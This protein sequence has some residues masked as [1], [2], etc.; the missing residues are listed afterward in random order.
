MFYICGLDPKFMDSFLGAI[1]AGVV[2]ADG[3]LSMVSD[4]TPT[5]NDRPLNVN[6]PAGRAPSL[7]SLYEQLSGSSSLCP[8]GS[9]QGGVGG[10][11]AMGAAVSG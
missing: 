8:R 10:V 11:G 2:S 6:P 3:D 1:S 9:C 5:D 7:L 4:P